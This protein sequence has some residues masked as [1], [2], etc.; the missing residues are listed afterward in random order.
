MISQR[1]ILN[2]V[3]PAK[4]ASSATV[5]GLICVCQVDTDLNML[6]AL[7]KECTELQEM[8]GYYF[9]THGLQLQISQLQDTV[10]L[11]RQLEAST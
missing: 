7:C 4:V 8:V 9:G 10:E 2:A 6:F 1:L 3:T 5:L 11:E